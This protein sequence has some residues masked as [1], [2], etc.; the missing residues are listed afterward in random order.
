VTD[1][2]YRIGAVGHDYQLYLLTAGIE[3][4]LFLAAALL[5]VDFTCGSR[6]LLLSG[7]VVGDG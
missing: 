6:R 2:G 4:R 1:D 7:I 3:R 5:C